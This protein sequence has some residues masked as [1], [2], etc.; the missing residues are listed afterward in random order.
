MWLVGW[1]WKHGCDSN[2]NGSGNRNEGGEG[3]FANTD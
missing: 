3:M 2:G 1:R